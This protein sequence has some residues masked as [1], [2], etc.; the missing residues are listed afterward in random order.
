MKPI[1]N[2]TKG[3]NKPA[4]HQLKCKDRWKDLKKIILGVLCV[5]QWVNESAFPCGGTS[6]MPSLEQ[7]VEDPVLL[8]LWSRL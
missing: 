6:S 8:Q 3:I 4:Y 2:H 7:W 1:S 5:A